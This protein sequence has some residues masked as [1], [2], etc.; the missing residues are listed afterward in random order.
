MEKM[1]SLSV[2]VFKEGTCRTRVSCP[3]RNTYP[4]LKVIVAI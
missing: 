2:I 1:R 3:V 4:N